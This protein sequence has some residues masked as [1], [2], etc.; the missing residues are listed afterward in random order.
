MEQSPVYL[1]AK[2][3]LVKRISRMDVNVQTIS[4]V[5]KF[6]MEIVETTQLKGKAQSDLV[7]KLVRQVVVEAPISDDEEKLLLDI[8]DQGM[9]ANTIDLIVSASKGEFDINKAV[10]LGA[11]CAAT[12]CKLS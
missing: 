10:T 3:E 9:L 6:A 1:Q 5:L 4:T 2:R 12:C 7:Q 8:I 11:K